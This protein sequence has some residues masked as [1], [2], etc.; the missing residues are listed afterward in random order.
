[1]KTRILRPRM[2]CRNYNALKA[3]C[4]RTN[5]KLIAQFSRD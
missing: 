3:P 5:Q 4:K 2:V 1:M